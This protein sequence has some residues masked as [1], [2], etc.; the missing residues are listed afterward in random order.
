MQKDMLDRLAAPLGR[1]DRDAQ[2]VQD[3]FLSDVTLEA[4]GA[5]RVAEARLFFALRFRVD[6]SFTCHER[7]GGSYPPCVKT[8]HLGQHLL[9]I[10]QSGIATFRSLE[11]P[12]SIAYLGP[13]ATNTHAAAIRK[14][15]SSVEYRPLAT[16]ADIFTAVEKGEADYGV[17]P[18]E[19]STEGSVRD[20]LDLFEHGL[21]RRT[22]TDD[23]LEPPLVWLPIATAAFVEQIRHT[24]SVGHWLPG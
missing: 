23:L 3:R 1:L 4:L 12:L 13:E 15:G 2:L 5:Q 24:N 22:R 18:V 20:S 17:V 11:K 10:G 8:E 16:I 19:N 21:Q 7:T 9:R 14:F 6:G